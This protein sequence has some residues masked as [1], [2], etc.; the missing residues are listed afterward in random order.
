MEMKGVNQALWYIRRVPEE[1]RYALKPPNNTWMHCLYTEKYLVNF[2]RIDALKD[3]WSFLVESNLL[4]CL[5][6]TEWGEI[7]GFITTWFELMH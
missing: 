1:L 2:S 4:L 5:S 6:V 7:E 3:L